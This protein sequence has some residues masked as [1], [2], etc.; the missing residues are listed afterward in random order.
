MKANKRI[1]D[2]QRRSKS[3]TRWVHVADR[4]IT[5]ITANPYTQDKH[6]NRV[7]IPN[8]HEVKR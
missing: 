8:V 2:L 6:G 1:R 7:R 3:L 4:C 5:P